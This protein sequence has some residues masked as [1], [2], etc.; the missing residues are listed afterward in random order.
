LGVAKRRIWAYNIVKN[1]KGGIMMKEYKVLI[2]N[3]SPHTHGSTARVLEEAVSI[4][5]ESG[6]ACDLVSIGTDVIRGCIGCGS[7]RKI[8]KCAFD[9]KVNEAAKLFEEADGII[10]GSPV[11]YASPN[12]SLI[13]FLDR[14]F[15]SSTFDKTMKVG[16]AVVCARRG[17]CT[18]SFDVLNKYFT[19]SGMPVASSTYWNQVHGAV[20]EDA[21]EDKEGLQTMRNLAHNMAFLI[22]SIS[23]GKE[24]L[25]MPKRESGARTNFIKR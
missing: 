16:A 22:K 12:G 13:S 19:I 6:V 18:A 11:Y 8:G 17:G 7:C 25:G 1:K 5:K 4:F 21:T 14:L 9:D 10:V 20:A 2:I 23:L 15:Y 24:K 3:G